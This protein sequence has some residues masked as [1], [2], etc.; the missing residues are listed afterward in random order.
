MTAEH[1]PSDQAAQTV[2]SV[3]RNEVSGRVAGHVVQAGIIHGD[4]HTGDLHVHLQRERVVPR[5]LVVPPR[6]FTGRKR[7]LAA[8]TYDLEEQGDAGATVA[9]SVIG[10]PGGMGKTALALHWAYQNIDRFPDGQLHVDLRGFDPSGEPMRPEVAV[11]GFL[12]ALGVESAAIPPGLDAQA[13]LYR[14]LVVGKR[15]L[16]VLDNARSSE[17]VEPLLPGSPTC[18]VL[19]T[20]RRQLTGLVTR[21]SARPLDLGVL[22]EAEARELFT[23]HVGAA[24]VATEPGAVAELLGWCADLPIAISVVAARA[25]RHATF[26]L[27]VLAEELREESARLDALDGGELTASLRAVFSWSHHALDREQAKVFGLLGLVP[28]PDISL[29][30]AAALT[31]LSLPRARAVL[32]ALEDASLIQQHL[33]GRYRM[34]DLLRLYATEQANDDQSPDNRDTA[35]RRLAD[36]HLHTAFAAGRLLEPHRPLIE[37]D[38]PLI[39][40]GHPHRMPD[41]AAALA[42]LDTEHSCLLATH[43]LAVTRGWHRVVWQLAWTLTAFHGRRGH[44]HD[45]LAVL[46]AGLSSARHLEDPTALLWAH[47]FLGAACALVGRHADAFDH[48]GQALGLAQDAHD[49]VGQIH[50]HHAFTWLWEAQEED[51]RALEHATSALRL[52]RRLDQPVWEADMLNSVSWFSARLGHYEQA[53]TDC[54]AALALSRRHRYPQG[55]AYA[56][57]SLGYLAHHTGDHQKAEDYYQQSLTLY[58]D[59]GD[60]YDEAIILDHL[61]QTQAALCH[62]DQA[63]HN[64]Q[65]ALKLYRIQHR[66]AEADRTQE[67]LD[68]HGDRERKNA[69]TPD[70]KD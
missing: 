7:Q 58:R 26:P 39:P 9:I 20:S 23:R 61:G 3:V 37:I 24:R 13:A 67:R 1:M 55:E 17:Q 64:W 35:L 43:R 65:Q 25:A 31:A 18:T 14:S 21:H 57:D 56:L 10:G 59:L 50:T 34:H 11:R 69:E 29:L 4:V 8:L 52:C 2:E 27:A 53:H 16:V 19:V 32:H 44:L 36:F 12:D 41:A 30:A 51:Q 45:D 46:Q 33:P 54:Q 70:E 40:G 49:V 48:L 15:M 66:A 6:L 5:Q 38:H 60:T 62:H 63:R 47:Q 22:T 42:W 28:G 68:E